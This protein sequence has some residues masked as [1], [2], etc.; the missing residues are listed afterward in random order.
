MSLDE[1]FSFLGESKLNLQRNEWEWSGP[2]L[3]V[4]SEK[5]TSVCWN[6][7][8]TFP[9]GYLQ[10]Q[11]R[12]EPANAARHCKN[13]AR[14]YVQ[15]ADELADKC[16]QSMSFIRAAALYHI[17]QTQSVS[18]R[19]F[20]AISEAPIVSI[21]DVFLLGVLMFDLTKSAAAK[22]KFKR[23]LFRTVTNQS[24]FHSSFEAA[25]FKCI[26]SSAHKHLGI[27]NEL[28]Y[29][30]LDTES[31]KNAVYEDKR[32]KDMIQRLSNLE[33][34]QED[35]VAQLKEMRTNQLARNGLSAG[36][37][38]CSG[39]QIAGY[40]L[41]IAGMVISAIPPDTMVKAAEQIFIGL[42]ALYDLTKRCTAGDDDV[43]TP[44]VLL[45]Q[46]A[47]E[48]VWFHDLA[49]QFVDDYATDHYEFNSR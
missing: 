45:N 5:K 1:K 44:K 19:D 47:L 17:L 41:P 35:V 37:V 27:L 9:K 14:R 48:D 12:C 43:Q 21:K 38:I 13:I 28:E 29:N 22:E 11:S 20:L 24:L 36:A 30:T 25:H 18:E 34:V 23:I 39:L 10:F 26:L 49:G 6:P 31:S 2:G 8:K 33:T 40:F 46:D 4:D 16:C 7:N 32:F 42:G 3:K 15:Q